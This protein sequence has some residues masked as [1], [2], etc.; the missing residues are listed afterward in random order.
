MNEIKEKYKKEFDDCFLA[1]G[2]LERKSKNILLQKP[3]ADKWSAVECIEHLNRSADIYITQI[4]KG[5]EKYGGRTAKKN[6]EKFKN[7]TMVNFMVYYLEPP[8]KVKIKTFDIFSPKLNKENIDKIFSD[9]FE[10][11][12]DFKELID[13]A[14]NY[15][16]KKVKVTSPLSSLIRFRLGEIFPFLAAH[17]RRHLWQAE[18]TIE[19]TAENLR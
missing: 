7:R 14:F 18:K 15:N 1:A 16:L 11:Q 9:F 17:Q 4:K 2:N 3:G 8:Y 5:I 10:Y 12:R 6:N 13:T 19:R